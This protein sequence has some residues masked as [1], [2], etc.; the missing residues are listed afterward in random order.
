MQE[1]AEF[2]KQGPMLQ[3]NAGVKYNGILCQFTG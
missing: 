3:V 1:L 2:P